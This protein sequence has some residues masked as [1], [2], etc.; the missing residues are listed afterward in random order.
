M[1]STLIYCPVCKGVTS[2]HG[3][4]EYQ[5][6]NGGYVSYAMCACDKSLTQKEAATNRIAD[7]KAEIARLEEIMQGGQP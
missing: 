3:P 5:A 2:M 4:F 7:L 1:T 6:G